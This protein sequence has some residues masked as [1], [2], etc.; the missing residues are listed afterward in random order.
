MRRSRG[1][2]MAQAIVVSAALALAGCANN[3]ESSGPGGPT[4]S[5]KPSKVDEIANLLPD[6]VKQSGKLI[7]GTDPTY[8][9]NEYKDSNGKII[10]FDVDLLNAVAAVLGVT[11]DYRESG[12]DN[13][14]PSIQGGSFDMGMSSFTDNKKR[15]DQV[16]FVDYFEAGS[17]WAQRPGSPVDPNNACGL[18]VAVQTATVQDTDELPAKNQACLQAGKPAINVLKFE[19]QDAATNAVMVG[20]ADAMS[21]DYPVTVSA[22]KDSAGKL[23]AAGALFKAAPYGWAIPKG[24]P[25]GQALLKALEHVMQTGDYKTI[26]AN[27][28]VQDGAI[29]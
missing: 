10:G 15:E 8:K 6:K 28:S 1:W 21:A 4:T 16:D 3:T 26:L 13:I 20:Q 23:Q 7:V 11:P 19:G 14:I 5:V 12:F 29:G 22:I 17:L 2:L 25:L 24:S 18:H 9:P 27:W